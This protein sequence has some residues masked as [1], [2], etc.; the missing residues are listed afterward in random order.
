MP[1]IEPTADAKRAEVAAAAGSEKMSKSSG[2]A[3]GTGSFRRPRTWIA[4]ILLLGVLAVGYALASPQ[5]RAW[6]HLRAARAD[7]QSYHNQQA[8]KHLQACRR[9]WPENAE[10]LLLCARAARREGAYDE[11]ER[12]LEKYREVRGLDDA[13]S[14]E[15]LLL[16]AERNVDQVDALCRRHIEQGH[17]DAAL[18]LE[19][20]ARGYLRQFRLQEANLCLELWLK[21][22][23]DNPQALCLVGQFHQ[24]YERSPD[25]AVESYRRAVQIDPENEEARLGLAIVLL[26][27]KS[28]GKAAEHLEYMRRC[29]P[30]NLRV[31]V[32][33]AQCRHSLGESDDALRMVEDVLARQP[34]Y[35]PAL[36]VRGEI[37]IAA[38]EY[39]EGERWLR[40]A[41]RVAPNDHQ[42]RYHLMLSLYHNGHV[43]EA[44]RYEQAI[45]QWEDDAKRFNKIVTEEMTGKPQDPDLQAELGV[46]LL[47]SGH[48]E[49][50]LRWLQNAL[51]LDPQ[52]AAARQALAEFYKKDGSRSDKGTN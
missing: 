52:H 45:K 30:D 7:L 5:L 50:G 49:E 51:R 12:G 6:H 26:E 20:L 29:Q 37:A 24:D 9:I 36:T 11:A 39:V 18:I 33:L 46:L 14:F 47:R 17:P 42:A 15:Q 4:L 31:Q 3:P 16:S 48:R 34:D 25:G 1:A 22:Q 35:G 27:T 40:Q 38:G 10:V 43:E 2:A 32:G 41:V 13:G 21:S 23:P 8:I 19:A 28:F 44:K